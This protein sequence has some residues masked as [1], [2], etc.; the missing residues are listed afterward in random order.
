MEVVGTA[1]GGQLHRLACREPAKPASRCRGFCGQR[2]GQAEGGTTRAA[3][4]LCLD[5]LGPALGLGRGLRCQSGLASSRLW[6]RGRFDS[7]TWQLST[8]L[9][10]MD[11]LPRRREDH[12]HNHLPTSYWLASPTRWRADCRASLLQTSPPSGLLPGLRLLDRVHRVPCPLA[13][14]CNRRPGRTRR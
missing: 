12:N 5:P 14:A 2:C 7:S 8:D 13:S 9:R 6:W 3:C 10:D 4:P 1:W 11:F